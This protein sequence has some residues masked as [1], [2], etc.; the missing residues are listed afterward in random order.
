M[1]TGY[2]NY[3][4]TTMFFVFPPIDTIAVHGKI[5]VHRK[6]DEAFAFVS[7]MHNDTAWRKEVIPIRH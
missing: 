2:S 4:H 5:V 3:K 7:D 1:Q 6:P